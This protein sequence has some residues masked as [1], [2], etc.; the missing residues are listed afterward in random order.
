MTSVSSPVRFG[1]FELDLHSGELQRNGHR[2]RLAEQPLQVLTLLLERPGQVITRE[3]LQRRLWRSDTF[4]EFEHGLNAAVKRL[5]EALGD[6]ADNPR[7]V[8]TLPRHGYRFIAP[9]AVEHA[10]ASDL[11][12]QPAKVSQVP[13]GGTQI[14]FRLALGAGLV[15]ATLA[16]LISLNANGIRDRLFG[17]RQLPRIESI[18]VL[19]LE[20]LSGDPE[21]EYFADGMTDALLTNLGGI[22]AIRVISRQSIM[23]YKGS[24][25]SLPEIAH[26]LDVDAIVEGTVQQSGGKVRITAQLVHGGT[27]RH[28]WAASYERDFRDVL[29]LEDEVALDIVQQIEVRLSPEESRRLSAARKVIPEVYEDYLKGRFQLSQISSRG[30]DSAA[31]YFQRALDKDPNYALAY[32]GIASVWL[33]RADAGYE[34]P[35]ET[36]PKATAAANKALQL[37]PNLSEA[38]VT[39]ANIDALYKRDWASA[40]RKFRRAI[41]LN[42]SN[43]NAHIMY[44]DYLVSLKREKEWQKEIQRALELDPMNSFMRTFYAWHLVYLGRCD[45]AIEMLTKTLTFQPGFASAHLGLWGAYFKKHMEAEAMQEAVRFFESIHDQEVAAALNAGYQKGGYKEGMHRGADI[46]ALR[47]RR[48]HVPAIRVARLYAHAGDKEQT[49]LWLNTAE[50]VHETPLMH[51]G[52]GWDWDFLRSDRRFQEILRR[53]NISPDAATPQ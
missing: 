26:E 8:E 31:H 53:M 39:L 34:P 10:A 33:M 32:A 12:V 41:E 51:L 43:A 49:L 38:Y 2:I 25:K 50:R 16:V 9:V 40:E 5:R 4:V 47:A 44:S 29:S 28:L 42:P 22:G 18:A 6:S 36:V 30:I 27:D 14:W 48:T 20:S 7:F 45:E 46:L 15:A 35:S 17:G 21:Q 3:E 11:Q 52:V 13:A 23:Q 1:S 37:D 24:K 19:P